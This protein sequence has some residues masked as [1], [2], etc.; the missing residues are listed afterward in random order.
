MYQFGVIGVGHM[1][2]AMAKRLAGAS[3]VAVFDTLPQAMQ[4]L[5]D[6][7]GICCLSLAE[8]CVQCHCLVVVVRPMDVFP[9]LAEINGIIPDN[10]PLLCMAAGV[11]TAD[12]QKT[13]PRGCALRGMPNTPA[14][15]GMGAVALSTAT[16]APEAVR[17]AIEQGLAPLGLVVWVAEEQMNAVTALSGS[18]P[19]YVYAFIDALAKAG[20]SLGLAPDA[21]LA[22]AMQTVQG[23][24]F[25]A[26]QSDKSLSALI[27]AVC[28]PGGTTEAAMQVLREKDFSAN[29]GEA[30]SAA[31]TR[32]RELGK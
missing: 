9:L 4:K 7:P 28:V 27:D 21:A 6:Y 15:I 1:G 25:F 13:L 23:S 32:A 30:V 17:R 2:A 10:L 16:T 24:A 29:L 19:A 11:T 8:I 3:P 5:A 31:A 22:L 26:D 20:T 14:Q 18:G 12:I